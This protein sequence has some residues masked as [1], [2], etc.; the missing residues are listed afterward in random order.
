MKDFF[1]ALGQFFSSLIK[2]KKFGGITSIVLI[3]LGVAFVFEFFSGMLFY[4]ELDRKVDIIEKIIDIKSNDAVMD[5][6]LKEEVSQIESSISNRKVIN[7]QG[8]ILNLDYSKVSFGKVFFSGGIW[9]LFGLIAVLGAMGKEKDNKVVGLLL[10]IFGFI[11]SLLCN[12]IPN[13][14]NRP[15]INSILYLLVNIGFIIL[16][17]SSTKK[18]QKAI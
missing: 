17:S 6:I 16:I 14:L 13:I 7:I 15:W 1:D 10:I 5:G 8:W 3:I 11:M 18:K 4:N 2:E 9:M 12:L